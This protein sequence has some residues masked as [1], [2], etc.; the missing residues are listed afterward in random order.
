LAL[1]E[2]KMKKTLIQ[3]LLLA[4]LLFFTSCGF[5]ATCPTYSKSN[6][7]ASFKSAERFHKHMAKKVYK[8]GR[9]YY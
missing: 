9:F 6:K 7:K 5:T 3:V 1:I 8:P 4:T 2:I